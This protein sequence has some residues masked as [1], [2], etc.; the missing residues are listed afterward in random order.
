M[1]NQHVKIIF[2]N[3][4]EA[5]QQ[6]RNLSICRMLT[7]FYA[8]FACILLI[9]V[10]Q[11]FMSCVF[12]LII[13]VYEKRRAQEH[14][15]M[16]TVRFSSDL[17][18]AYFF[19]VWCSVWTSAAEV[20]NAVAQDWSRILSAKKMQWFLHP[21]FIL[22]SSFRHAMHII[23]VVRMWKQWLGAQ[24]AR[25]DSPQIHLR[26]SSSICRLRFTSDSNQNHFKF[27]HFKLESNL[28]QTQFSFQITFTSNSSLIHLNVKTLPVQ[29]QLYLTLQ[30]RHF[31]LD[32]QI[33]TRSLQPD[34]GIDSS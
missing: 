16:Q 29:N 22:S 18:L 12:F 30:V 2:Q 11:C 27:N 6:H 21:V 31:C 13:A 28:F 15:W 33:Q 1:H 17:C 23:S 10:V 24:F 9:F 20:W 7:P 19:V 26:I 5:E 14:D 4:S 32:L 25:S 3:Q 8:M 34:W